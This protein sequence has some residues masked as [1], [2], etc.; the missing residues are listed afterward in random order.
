MPDLSYVYMPWISERFK[1]DYLD[2][3]S[4][5]NAILRYNYEDLFIM[6]SGFSVAYNRNDNVAIKA[7][8]E[9]AGNLL[10]MTNSIAKFKKKRTRTS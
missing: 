8:I 1:A 4:N 3:V 7:K 9:S 2:N 10:S 5:R 6:R